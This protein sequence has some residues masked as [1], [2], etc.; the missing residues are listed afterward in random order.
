MVYRV[1][2]LEHRLE[3]FRKLFDDNSCILEWLRIG[4]SIVAIYLK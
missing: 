2:H 3:E 1:A 4:D